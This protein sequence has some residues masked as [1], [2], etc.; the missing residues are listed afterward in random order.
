MPEYPRGKLNDADE[1]QLTV[2][3]AVHDKTVIIHFGKPIVWIGLASEDA[4]A[5]AKKLNQLADEIDQFAKA[6][7][8]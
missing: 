2:G 3:F 6:K 1:G 7:D 8:G 4:R 5:W